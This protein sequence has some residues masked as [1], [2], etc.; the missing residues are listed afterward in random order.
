MSLLSEKETQSTVMNQ[1]EVKGDASHK[2]KAPSLTSKYELT[3]VR[4]KKE[5]DSLAC[6]LTNISKY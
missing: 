4:E 6:S 1:N 2:K 5:P 3:Y